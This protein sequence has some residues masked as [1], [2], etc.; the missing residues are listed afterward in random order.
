MILSRKTIDVTYWLDI[1]IP[2]YHEGEWLVQLLDCLA[3]Q[4]QHLGGVK[5]YVVHDREEALGL[6]DKDGQS[7]NVQLV[8]SA[9]GIGTARNAGAAQGGAS[10]ILFLDADGLVPD[11]FLAELQRVI[12]EHQPVAATFSFFADSFAWP[13][14]LGTRLCWWYLRVSALF[15]KAALP[16]FATLVQ[17][18]AFD[19]V[20]GYRTDLAITE[21][22]A[23]SDDLMSAGYSI[24][25]FSRPW[26]VYAVRRFDL[27]FLRALSLLWWY[28]VIDVRRRF[29]GKRI[30]QGEISY[31]FGKH[32]PPP[33][34]RLPRHI[35]AR[36]LGPS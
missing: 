7:L 22:F 8:P 3:R 16:G 9:R 11:F 28:L 5:I 36:R 30:Y 34:R 31:E 21:D 33:N 2:T 27:P 6:P 19:E 13:F 4:K 14:R 35:K 18:A 24:S 15:G 17:R 20:G 32:A 12:R 23:L 1:V 26:L 29:H 25:V 10:W